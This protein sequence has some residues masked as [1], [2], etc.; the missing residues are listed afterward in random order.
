VL[1]DRVASGLP[2]QVGAGIEL[3][4]KGKSEPQTAYHV[5]V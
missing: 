2:L 3:T 4:L 1:S 5:S